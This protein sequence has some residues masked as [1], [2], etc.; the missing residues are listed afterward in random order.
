MVTFK[1]I[2]IL[3]Y[4]E[5]QLLNAAALFV[6]S[7]V[8]I[9]AEEKKHLGAIVG[10]DNYKREYVDELVKDWNSHS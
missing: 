1:S 8:N 6:N 3:P 7:N 10:R 2:K 4:K 9:T 5:D